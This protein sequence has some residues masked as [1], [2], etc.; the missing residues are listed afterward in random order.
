[1]A[2]APPAW[3]P[4]WTARMPERVEGGCALSSEDALLF[5]PGDAAPASALSAVTNVTLDSDAGR[6][7]PRYQVSEDGGCW[8]NDWFDTE[9]Q[10]ACGFTRSSLDKY[11]CRPDSASA[12]AAVVYAFT[13]SACTL[14][15]PIGRLGP[16]DDE[17]PTVAFG[18]YGTAVCMDGFE[19]WRTGAPIAAPE[20]LAYYSMEGGTCLPLTL[21]PD[22][23]YVTLTGKIEDSELVEGVLTVE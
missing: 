15:H 10:V 6:L 2:G 21:D 18:N 7:K 14:S 4:G 1:M 16:C 3:A 23:R 11:H 5:E 8:F 22:R 19:V 20:T 17:V 12:K 9:L 13:D